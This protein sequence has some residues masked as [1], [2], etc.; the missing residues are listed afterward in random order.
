MM[1]NMMRAGTPAVV[2]MFILLLLA[3][4][5]GSELPTKLTLTDVSVSNISSTFACISYFSSIPA[6]GQIQYGTSPDNLNMTAE[7]NHIRHTGLIYV[8]LYG[9]KENTRYY[10]SVFAYSGS[11]IGLN[12]N[13]GKLYSFKTTGDSFTSPYTIYGST[14]YID[15]GSYVP[16]EDAVAFFY[17]VSGEKKTLLQSNVTS[18]YF[19]SFSFNTG[20]LKLASGMGY[21]IQLGDMIVVE[22]YAGSLGSGKNMT[23]Y[24]GGNVDMGIILISPGGANNI[25]P[26]SGPNPQEK[27][28]SPI[29]S[30]SLYVFIILAL[31]II[32]LL[33]KGYSY[34][35]KTKKQQ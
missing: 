3:P 31:I 22:V 24:R 25:P 4:A 34:A 17:V 14:M 5:G 7:D 18:S 8:K 15:N 33:I 16:V 32:A 29:N 35:K 9:L 11:L 6:R 28:K 23:R 30:T 10:F 2:L 13:G 21:D 12:D 1:R 20:N 26:T 27:P 19:G